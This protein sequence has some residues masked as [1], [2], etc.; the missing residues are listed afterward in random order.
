MKFRMRFV[1]AALAAALSTTTLAIT[2]LAITTP[3]HAQVADGPAQRVIV[4]WRAQIGAASQSSAASRAVSDAEARIGISST[5]LRTT[6][7]GAEVVRLNRR[8]TQAELSDFIATLAANPAVEYVEEDRLMKRLLT[9]TD[10]RYSEQWHYYEATAGLNLPLAWDITNGAGVTVAVLDTGYRPHADL[11]ANIVGG[12][13]FISDSFVGNDGDARDSNAQDPGDWNTAGQCPPDPN[14]Y[15]SSWHGTHVAGTIAAVTNNGS[16]V[17]GVAYGARVLPLRVLGR[18][19]GY[20][21]DIADAIVWASGG[22]VSGA[23]TN[24]NVAKVINMSLG[25][26]GAAMRRLRAPSTALVLAARSWSS[27]P[28][29]RIRM[30]PT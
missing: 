10:T 3:A 15:D 21:S 11:A 22:A 4:K 2:T 19:G 13:D 26:Q 14:A 8:V 5:S 1:R 23:P 20:T 25:G 27:P 12:Y 17:A 30:S 28:A 9:P 24:A 16:G 18:C 7:A 29:T 6:A